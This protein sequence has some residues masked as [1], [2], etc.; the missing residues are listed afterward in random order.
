MPLY[1]SRE[2]I[3]GKR[4]TLGSDA[5]AATLAMV[6]QVFCT[7]ARVRE[8]WKVGMMCACVGAREKAGDGA[9]GNVVAP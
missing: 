1:Y 7:G 4:G 9:G 6:L 2:K 3:P 8:G 5:V